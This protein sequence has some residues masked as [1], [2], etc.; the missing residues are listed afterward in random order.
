MRYGHTCHN[1]LS[2]GSTLARHLQNIVGPRRRTTEFSSILLLL[3]H[4]IHFAAHYCCHVATDP[5]SLGVLTVLNS[6][7]FQGV[8]ARQ[9]SGL[10]RLQPRS[11]D[12]PSRQPV[13]LSYIAEPSQNYRRAVTGLL[14]GYRSPSTRWRDTVVIPTRR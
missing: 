8:V 4:Q 11:G 12:T 3:L 5:K 6:Q 13:F 1:R 7:P 9:H 2:A 14:Q 10:L